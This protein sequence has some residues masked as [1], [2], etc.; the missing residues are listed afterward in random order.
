MALVLA[1]CGTEVL[2]SNLEESDAN[3]IL[4]LLM[5]R[6]ISGNK[7]VGKENKYS[8]LV[9][10]EDFAKAVDLL[11]WYGVPKKTFS[12]VG[13]VFQK[14]G[15][16]STPTEEFIRFTFALSQDI[17]KMLSHIDGVITSSVQ[18]V[19]PQ[20]DPYTEASS[21]SSASVFLKFRPGDLPA[22]LEPQ[23]KQLV[24]NSVQG[25]TYEKVAVT[26]MQSE[27]VDLFYPIQQEQASASLFGVQFAKSS[28]GQVYTI[29]GVVGG[30][31]VVLAGA[32]GYLL[33]LAR[34][35]SAKIKPD[36]AGED[37]ATEDALLEP[38]RV[39]KN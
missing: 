35:K 29:A 36:G 4:G 8:V 1:G 9:P 5:A 39:A 15:M 11:E 27:N 7:V 14:T 18:L 33:L 13:E 32:A 37:G 26:V 17:A 38:I 19:L 22:M 31:V 20:N 24:M 25:L 16:V 3:K 10:R 30:L 21:P 12:G 6:D 23:V 34:R 28:L 2:Y